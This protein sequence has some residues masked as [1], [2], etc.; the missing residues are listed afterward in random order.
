MSV[1]LFLAKQ[2]EIDRFQHLP[3]GGY[4]DLVFAQCPL[5][6]FIE[7]LDLGIVLVMH[8]RQRRLDQHVLDAIV[9]MTGRP[10][11]FL[12]PRLRPGRR[13]SGIRRQVPERLE[14]CDVTYLPFEHRSGDDA[15][16]RHR[17]HQ[18]D[19]VILAVTLLDHG[20]DVLQLLDR[21]VE[22]VE[23]LVDD[24]YAQA[25]NV[26]VELVREVRLELR[27]DL[28]P[29][30]IQCPDHFPLQV[31]FLPD[32]GPPVP[33]QVPQFPYFHGWNVYPI[34]APQPKQLGEDE[35]VVPVGLGPGL[36]QRFCPVRMHD[37]DLMTPS[38]D[39]VVDPE[40][41][42]CRLD[43]DRKVVIVHSFYLLK[44]TTDVFDIGPYPFP[45]NEL[46]VLVQ[47]AGLS[48]LFMYVQSDIVHGSPS[49]GCLAITQISGEPLLT[50]HQDETLK[51]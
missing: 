28:D 41:E 45:V 34:Q 31:P 39:D 1:I 15:N 27:R 7:V 22:K 14:P 4:D 24:E 18:L 23:L 29:V 38:D 25:P 8:V 3:G 49:L 44:E 46:T 20:L 42:A 35:G 2:H 10:I 40:I 33:G 50:C 37:L 43:D 12:L 13:Q 11:P 9:A 5:L 16:A 19:I 21:N 47:N 48:V 6:S 32:Q 51:A 26:L 36:H 17:H 30:L